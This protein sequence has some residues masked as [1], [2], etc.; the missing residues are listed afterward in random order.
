MVVMHDHTLRISIDSAKIDSY[1]HEKFTK[2]VRIEL[3][4]I[5]GFLMEINTISGI[6]K[7]K[8]EE[9][10]QFYEGKGAQKCH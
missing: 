1:N 8:I 5:R 10:D 7:E 9:L 4:S 3:N 6:L 2:E